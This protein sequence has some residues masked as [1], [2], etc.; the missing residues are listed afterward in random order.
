[1]SEYEVMH[2]QAKSLADMFRR[3]GTW[4]PATSDEPTEEAQPHDV[5][6]SEDDSNYDRSQE[7]Y[8]IERAADPASP[9]VSLGRPLHRRERHVFRYFLDGSLR[10]YYMGELIEGNKGFPILAAEIASAVMGRD[11]DGRMRVAGFADHLTILTPPNPP[12]SDGTW[13][14]LQQ[15]REQF[16]ASSTGSTWEIRSLAPGEEWK[17]LR[18]SLAGLARSI[19]HDTELELASTVP[20]EPSQWLIIDGAIRKRLFLDLDY[21][22]G[23]A[24][25]FSRRPVFRIN[26]SR[27]V[28]DIV[29]MLSGLREGQ[30]TVVFKQVA[31][32]E[33]GGDVTD[34]SVKKKIALWYLKLR[35]GRGLE[36][37][38]QGVV[39]VEIRHER[40]DLNEE[41]VELVN[42]LSRALLAERYVSPYPVPRWHAHIYPIYTAENY[43]KARMRSSIYMRGLL[44]G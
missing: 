13:Q 10:T 6:R 1:M 30:R 15:I 36:G 42:M 35:S 44:R 12:L 2:N 7:C 8:N 5:D 43:I 11:D 31:A 21:T 19:M 9:Y 23:L 26:R 29:S 34:S 41:E 27:S 18:T 28:R 39:K 38:L 32:V 17:D 3:R 37:P 33:E 14:E 16:S 24:K 40:E 22:I 4:L 25:S 20:R